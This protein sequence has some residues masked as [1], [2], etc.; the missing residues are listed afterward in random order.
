MAVEDLATE[1][2]GC[3]QRRSENHPRKRGKIVIKVGQRKRAIYQKTLVN[4]KRPV[5]NKEIRRIFISEQILLKS[6]Q[7]QGDNKRMQETSRVIQPSLVNVQTA[8]IYI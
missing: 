1:H 2:Q 8:T 5:I 6:R 7:V 4:R 3:C